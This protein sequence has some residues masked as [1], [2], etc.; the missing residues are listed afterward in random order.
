M[1]TMIISELPV[2]DQTMVTSYESTW[3]DS[4][5]GSALLLPKGWAAS[6]NP[7]MRSEVVSNLTGANFISAMV[8]LNTPP[9]TAVPTDQLVI[10]IMDLCGVLRKYTPRVRLVLDVPARTPEWSRILH[11]LND[12]VRHRWTMSKQFDIRDVL[13]P[14][15]VGVGTTEVPRDLEGY[16]T[17]RAAAY[18]M[19][20]VRGF[21]RGL[22]KS[23]ELGLTTARSGLASGSEAN[24]TT[25][26]SEGSKAPPAVVHLKPGCFPKVSSLRVSPYNQSSKDQP[27]GRSKV[28]RANS[29]SAGGASNMEG[30]QDITQQALK[31]VA[32]LQF[33]LGQQTPNLKVYRREMREYA[34]LV[35]RD[36]LAALTQRVTVL[37]SLL[38][39]A[40]LGG[41]TSNGPVRWYIPPSVTTKYYQDR[42]V[43]KCDDQTSEPP[44]DYE[45]VTLV[46]TSTVEA[47]A[48]TTGSPPT[49]NC[50][51]I[52]SPPPTPDL[53]DHLTYSAPASPKLPVLPDCYDSDSGPDEEAL[54]REEP[55]GERD[56]HTPL[57]DE[58]G[59]LQL[60]STVT[61]SK[62]VA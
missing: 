24:S 3:T 41:V 45:P 27:K 11:S 15:F 47:C 21:A 9:T 37:E 19:E 58:P 55:S 4:Q 6:W 8:L 1:A 22:K 13:T 30:V 44:C 33:Q 23:P 38:P 59:N 25:W 34:D 29:N 28:K 43:S 62:E 5:P 52:R 36:Q 61:E 50:A 56:L 46:P 7:V 57:L 40:N 12:K 26:Y 49:V 54:L 16:L 10:N 32:S 18:H 20:Q 2:G 42:A 60:L 17:P 35:M 39:S 48:T 31:Q 51:L 53:T 14:T